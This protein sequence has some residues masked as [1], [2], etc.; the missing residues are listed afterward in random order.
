MEDFLNELAVNYTH[1]SRILELGR[2][3]HGLHIWG[4]EISPQDSSPNSDEPNL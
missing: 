1:I 2:S 4:L 3:S